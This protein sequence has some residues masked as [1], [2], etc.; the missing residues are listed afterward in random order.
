[1]AMLETI[2]ILLMYSSETG[3]QWHSF[4]ETDSLKLSADILATDLRINGNYHFGMLASIH[5]MFHK[6]RII[7]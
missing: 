7:T 1:M 6:S 3:K 5:T 2:S 4:G